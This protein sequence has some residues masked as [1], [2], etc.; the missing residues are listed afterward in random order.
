[1]L[2][3]A[4]HGSPRKGNSDYTI[5][6]IKKTMSECGNAEF[7]DIYLP[8]DLPVFCKGCFSC[9]ARGKYAGEICP[10]KQYTHPILEKLKKADGIIFTSPS[11]AL[12]E[13]GSVKV[14]LDHFACTYIN[15]RPNPE[16]FDK[17]AI[18]V[19][20][21]AGAGTKR[22]V[23]TIK[24]NLLFWGI[25]R[26]VSV[27]IN[28][29]AGN[30]SEMEDSKRVKAEKQISKNARKFY[31]LTE[32]RYKIRACIEHRFLRFIFKGLIKKHIETNPDKIY[33]K[34]HGW[35]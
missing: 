22:A 30:W 17:T 32:N 3:C 7:E 9:L 15:H 11:Y 26:I 29:W 13:S 18:I 4:V 6:L 21:A 10:D 16:M 2:I 31:K 34:E 1:M 5:E 14:F 25:K 23:S 24:R 35:I 33:W 20:T 19:S 27:R 12:S 28:L 8:K